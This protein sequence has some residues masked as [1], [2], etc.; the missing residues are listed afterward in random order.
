MNDDTT[1][2]ARTAVARH[3]ELQAS[4]ATAQDQARAYCEAFAA[5]DGA[6]TPAPTQDDV[7]ALMLRATI[8]IL[9]I[10]GT[11]M[12]PLLECALAEAI[13]ERDGDA[14]N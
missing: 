2:H 1:D 4:I 13:A 7:A 9:E 8:T 10:A 12:V 14:D 5:G 3:A 6:H 11:D